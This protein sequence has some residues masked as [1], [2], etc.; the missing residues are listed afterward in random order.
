MTSSRSSKCPRSFCTRS[1]SGSRSWSR[2]WRSSWWKCPCWSWSSWHAAGAQAALPGAT[3]R[4]TRGWCACTTLGGEAPPAQGGF[5]KLGAEPTLQGVGQVADVPVIMLHKSQQSL[6]IES[7]VPFQLCYSDR[8]CFSEETVQKTVEVPQLQLSWVSSRSRT[9]LLLCPL[10]Q[11]QGVRAMLGLTV[12][13]CSASVLGWL[14]EEFHDFLRERVDSDSEVDYVLLFSG[15]ATLVVNNGSGMC[16]TGFAGF[17]V[18]RAVFPTLVGLLKE[19]SI[20]SRC[21]GCRA[22]FSRKSR[23]FFYEP[24]VSCGH[25]QLSP[26]FA[27]VDF[28]EPSS[29]NSCGLPGDSAHAFTSST[30]RHNHNHNHNHNPTHHTPHTTH[31]TTHNNN[32]KAQTGLCRFFLCDQLVEPGGR[33]DAAWRSRRRMAAKTATPALMV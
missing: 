17:C 15:V 18:P 28:L 25:S 6:L 23:Q 16:C 26:N 7:V 32:N 2:R 21:L 33:H 27:R 31:H 24:P 12:S 14:L 19:R 4:G 9:W 29:T 13:T 1:H 20:H 3:Q 10:V 5:Q 22:V 11:R 30:P 8:C